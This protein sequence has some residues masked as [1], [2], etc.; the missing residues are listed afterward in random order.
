MKSNKKNK[1][2]KGVCIQLCS[3]EIEMNF[4]MLSP[5]FLY[6]KG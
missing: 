6:S 4:G 1:Y 3:Q 2:Y 5:D